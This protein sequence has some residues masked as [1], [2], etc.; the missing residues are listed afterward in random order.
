MTIVDTVYGREVL[1]SRGN[2]TVEVEISL[3]DGGVGRAIVPSG[4]STGVHEA[5][6]KRDGEEARYGGKGVLSAVDAVNEEIADA[7]IGWDATDQVGIDELMIELDGTENKERLGANAILGVSLAVAKA[8]AD[9]LQLPLYRYLGGVSARTLPVPMMNIMNGGKHAAGSTDLQEFMV[10]PISAPSFSE[11]VR[12]CVEIYHSLK[13]TLS[14]E[15]HRTLVGD[16]GGFAPQLSANREAFELIIEATERAGY[17]MGE[18]IMLAMD[19]AASEIYEDG[20]Y[21]LKTE[22][23]VL[24]GAELVDLYAQW[25]DEYPIISIE[26]G[27]HEDDWDSWTLM[28]ERLGDKIQVV[29][30][31]LLVTNA[32]RIETAM[33]RRAANSLLCKVNQ[34]G[35]LTESIGAVEMVQRRGWTAVVSHRSGETEDTTIADLVVAL[36]AGQLKTGAPARTDRVAKYNQLLRIED[37]LGSSA[38]YPGKTAFTNLAK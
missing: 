7:L 9:S 6:E 15:G 4:A 17:R 28:M 5:W 26:D 22:G 27:H 1:D 13:K 35:T 3:M 20:K 33:D 14:N 36:N 12:W 32:A 16:E 25:V 2:P 37:E 29:G 24:T 23:A 11:G 34:I 31:D 8:A 38:V 30:D 21:H 19:A 10:M 18:Q